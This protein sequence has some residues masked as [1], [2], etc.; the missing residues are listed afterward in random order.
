MLC[1]KIPAPAE[2]NSWHSLAER[3]LVPA[4]GALY[5]FR[6]RGSLSAAPSPS[7]IEEGSSAFPA[8]AL[9]A[10]LPREPK[11][12]HPASGLCRRGAG[13]RDRE[14]AVAAGTAAE[15]EAGRWCAVVRVRS[16]RLPREARELAPKR[17]VSS[18]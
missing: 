16:P 3:G 14:G 1:S 13:A 12:L 15:Q 6:S 11:A 7:G 5:V 17:S 9:K 8:P 10:P 18:L 4:V 2:G